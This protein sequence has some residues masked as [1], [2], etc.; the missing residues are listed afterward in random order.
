MKWILGSKYFTV[1]IVKLTDI[2]IHPNTKKGQ[3]YS[4]S[5]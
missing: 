5:V 1:K 2:V 4:L 3:K